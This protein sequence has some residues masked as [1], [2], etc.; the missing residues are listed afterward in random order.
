VEEDES[1]AQSYGDLAST[2]QSV[3][4]EINAVLASG[5]LIP[6][7]NKLAELKARMGIQQH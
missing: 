2:E 1:L 3:D 5:Q 6:S 4:D 7:S